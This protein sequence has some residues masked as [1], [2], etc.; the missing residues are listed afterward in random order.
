[1]GD[2][3]TDDFVHLENRMLLLQDNPSAVKTIAGRGMFTILFFCFCFCFS[4]FVISSQYCSHHLFG[5][6]LFYSF[7]HTFSFSLTHFL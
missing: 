7:S 6:S 2:S 4:L 5:G 3:K 1:M